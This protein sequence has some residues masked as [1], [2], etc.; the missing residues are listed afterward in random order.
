MCVYL[1][2]CLSVCVKAMRFDI[3]KP[4]ATKL[5]THTK[6]FAG[7]RFEARFDK[8]DLSEEP[9]FVAIIFILLY[10]AAMA[11]CSTAP[12]D[13]AV[14]TILWAPSTACMHGGTTRLGKHK[15]IGNN[16]IG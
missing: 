13:G 1:S 9:L 15:T 4:I 6:R 3:P 14:R 10:R 7:K 16:K 8:L 5:Y 12:R 11:S 2:V